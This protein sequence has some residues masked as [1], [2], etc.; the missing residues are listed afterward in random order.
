MPSAPPAPL[1]QPATLWVPER[2]GSYGPEIIDWAEGIGIS[3]DLEQRRDID[4]LASYGPGGQWLTPE[5]GIIEGRQ[6]GKTKSVLLPIALADLFLFSFEPDRI[7]WTSH[8]MKTSRDTFT[9]VQELIA[10]NASLSRRVKEIVEA[11]SEEAIHLMDGSSLEFV[12]RTGGGGRGL[13]GKRIVFDEA[14]FLQLLAM[15][16]L[17]PTLRARSNPQI[18]Y[19]SSAGKP[20]SDHLRSLQARGRRGGDPGLILVEYRAEGGWDKPGCLGG[21][22]CTHIFGVE[23]CSLDDEARWRQGNHAIG[24][25]RMRIQALRDE[26]SILCRTLEGV[27]EFGREALG[28]EELGDDDAEKPISPEGWAATAVPADA[29]KPTGRPAFFLDI[30]PDL[31][32]ASIGVAADR[33]GGVPHAELPGH[34]LGI[35]WLIA[36]VKQ[37]H[38][39]HPDAKWGAMATGSPSTMVTKLKALGIELELLT[40]QEMARACVHMQ[41]LTTEPY[42]VTHAEDPDLTAAVAG[43]AKKNVG[44]GLWVLT[45]KNVSVDLSPLYAQVG[46]CWLLEKHRGIDP[47]DNIY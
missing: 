7:F 6:N 30:S 2:V 14:L 10:A 39:D 40:E 4:V 20:E 15:G 8:L 37:L 13:G 21:T 29:P 9:R 25:G 46:A 11:K 24:R 38:A 23:G 28:W 3:M 16:S 42:G 12:A 32:S 17:L 44:E 35:D 27:L 1:Q 43:A 22:K 33:D 18:N 5:A 36:R 41:T 31:A 47:L 45:R 34:Q 19:G 26:R